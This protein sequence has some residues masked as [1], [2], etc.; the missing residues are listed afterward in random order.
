MIPRAVGFDKGMVEKGNIDLNNRPRVKN[1]D[2]SISTVRS[3]G[4]EI[5]G[6]HVLIPTVSED[7]RI[8]TNAEAIQQFKKTGKHLGVFK[9]D[10]D[11]DAYAQKLHEDQA[12]LIGK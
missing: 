12:K 9:T 10:K 1:K 6:K 8:M 11:A 2:G 4:I 5:D 7:G 3:I